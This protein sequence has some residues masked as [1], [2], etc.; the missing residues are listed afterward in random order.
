MPAGDYRAVT[1]HAHAIEVL[2]QRE[3]S[4]DGQPVP[5]E[6]SLPDLEVEPDTALKVFSAI[7][8]LDERRCN[9]A[10]V[11]GEVPFDCTGIGVA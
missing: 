6:R 8:A 3:D 1:F 2:S 11:A 5:L 10:V 9:V 4:L 7:V